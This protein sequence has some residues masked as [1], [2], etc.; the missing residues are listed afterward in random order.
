LRDYQIV[1]GCQTSH[2]LYSEREKINDQLFVPVKLVFT[3]DEEIAQ[4][5]T[6][7]T[8]RQTPIEESDLLALTKFQRD[9]ESYYS[10]FDG[11]KKLYYERRSKQ[12]ANTGVDRVKIVPIGSQ[13]KVFASMFLEAPHQAGRYQATLL[14][15]VKDRVFKAGHRPEPY[16]TSAFAFYRFEGFL[17]KGGAETSKFKPFKFHFLNAFRYLYEPCNLPEFKDKKIFDYCE[18]LNK[19][20]WDKEGAQNAFS[21]C[22]DLIMRAASSSGFSLGPF[23]KVVAD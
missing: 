21:R 19:V 14:A 22:A 18:H 12:Y 9:L 1:N 3:G 13:L 5:V 8:N 6:K 7:S 23:C 4:D 17:K 2:V 16:Y 10:G 20:L 11:E 15:A